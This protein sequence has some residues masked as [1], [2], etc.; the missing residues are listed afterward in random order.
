MALLHSVDAAADAAAWRGAH[1][2]AL[3]E[4][5]F[6]LRPLIYV[7]ALRRYSSPT[8]SNLVANSSSLSS[9]SASLANSWKPWLLSLAVD[10]LSSHLLRRGAD[11]S[12][13][14]ADDAATRLAAAGAPAAARAAA[15]S[16]EALGWS[17]E[18][19][20]ELRRR[21]ALL[22]L[23]L[24]RSPAFDAG[25][26][27]IVDGAESVLSKVPLLGLLATRAADIVRGVTGYY[28]Y[29]SGS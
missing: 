22:A 18:E 5:L 10:L 24:L 6:V 8:R 19:L 15:A 2:M 16:A 26:S 11:A 13:A 4:V 12:R 1:A 3:G 7:L 23:Y 29:T 28:T 27:P 20:A 21:R 25:V 14:A 17:G 9:S